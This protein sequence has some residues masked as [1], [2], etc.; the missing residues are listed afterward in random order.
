MFYN[1]VLSKLYRN[2]ELNFL[3]NINLIVSDPKAN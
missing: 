2:D 3:V 1:K